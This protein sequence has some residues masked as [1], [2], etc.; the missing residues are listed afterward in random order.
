MSV[1]PC[2][3][4]YA[5]CLWISVRMSAV[6]SASMNQSSS[7]EESCPSNVGISCSMF[8]ARFDYFYVA[9]KVSV[10]ACIF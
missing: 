7:F 4:A 5:R 2:D 3:L 1:K 6:G 8:M 10:Y 9:C